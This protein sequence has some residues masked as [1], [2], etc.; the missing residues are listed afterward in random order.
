MMQI[1]I[2]LSGFLTIFLDTPPHRTRYRTSHGYAVI[3]GIS[4]YIYGDHLTCMAYH[5]LYMAYYSHILGISSYILV[6]SLCPP[7]YIIFHNWRIMHAYMAYHFTY[8][9]HRKASNI[10]LKSTWSQL[11]HPTPSSKNL[12]LLMIRRQVFY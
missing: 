1:R 4:L 8:M 7:R 12:C 2:V 3:S 10:K 6:V 9:T 5:R 11:A